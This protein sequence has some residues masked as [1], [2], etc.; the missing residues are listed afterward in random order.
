ML[1]PGV[2]NPNLTAEHHTSTC[3]IPSSCEMQEKFLPAAP[4]G[5]S[6]W[7]NSKGRQKQWNLR[8]FNVQF[9]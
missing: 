4:D 6:L 9:R 8:F 3:Y 2:K 1:C 7:L 5:K